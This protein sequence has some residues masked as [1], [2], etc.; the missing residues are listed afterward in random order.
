[1]KSSY[2]V[3]EAFRTVQGEGFHAGTASVFVRFAGCNLW[4][5]YDDDRAR[6]AERNGAHCPIFCDTDFRHG[7]AMSR[8]A[9]VALITAL[10][11]G[12]IQ[13]VVFTGG[14]PLLHLDAALILTLRETPGGDEFAI[15][16]ETNGTVRPRPGVL[17]A[18]E[19]LDEAT[20]PAPSALVDWVCCSPKVAREHLKLRSADELK[21]VV[22]DY[23]PD[24]FY[25]F[26]AEHFYVQ[27]RAQT[28]AVGRS[29]LDADIMARAADYVIAN[30]TWKLG[31]QTHKIAGVP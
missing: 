2:R 3:V 9:L 14:E 17:L 26:D 18:C 6:D 25:G 24:D 15:A 29:V 5:G 28:S 4:S 1:M 19:G 20:A 23:N 27:P 13:H 30:P 12:G 10:R 16:V 11:S 31:L 7:E 8:E 22:P 21:V